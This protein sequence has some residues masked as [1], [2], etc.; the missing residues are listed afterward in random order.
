MTGE[1]GFGE[2]KQG[3]VAKIRRDKDG[4]DPLSV[5]PRR[6]ED[7]TKGLD[8]L[9]SDTGKRKGGKTQQALCWTH[10]SVKFYGPEAGRESILCI[11]MEAAA[12]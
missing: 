2:K 6:A 10:T 1:Y 9:G 4:W 12:W 8:S 3:S 5:P 7:G 11:N